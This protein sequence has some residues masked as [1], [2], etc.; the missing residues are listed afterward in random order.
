MA[1]MLMASHIAACIFF[2]IAKFENFDS[3]T[4]VARRGIVN[5]HPL[6]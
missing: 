2:M 1:N 5:A 6:S 3:D 4:W